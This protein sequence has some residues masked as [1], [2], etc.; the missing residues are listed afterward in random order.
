M[1]IEFWK[2]TRKQAG[3]DRVPHLG[4]PGQ[5]SDSEALTQRDVT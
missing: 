2:V 5:G 3:M 4:S 1:Q